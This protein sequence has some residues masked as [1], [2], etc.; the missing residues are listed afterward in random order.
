MSH[1]VRNRLMTMTDEENGTDDIQAL[2]LA[3]EEDLL[4]LHGP[5]LT[6]DTL[7]LALGY[8]SKDAFRQS[9]VRKTVPVPLFEMENRRGKY[10]LTK[11]VAGFLARQRYQGA[12]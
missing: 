1:S 5:V 8:V 9:I 6:G 12:V 11:D 4:R 10:A 3:L 7:R 2:A